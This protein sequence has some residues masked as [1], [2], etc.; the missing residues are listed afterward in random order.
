VNKIFHVAVREFVATVATKGFI[1]GIVITPIIILV[2]IF[3]MRTLFNEEAPRIEGE[4]TVIDPTGEVFDGIH[5]YLQPETIAER[6]G[7]LKE[8]AE[9]QVPAELKQLADSSGKADAA[10][11]ALDAVLG[12]V[13]QL[14]VVRLDVRVDPEKAKEPLRAGDASGGGRLALIMIHDDAVVKQEDRERFGSYDLFVKEKL[15]DRIEDE[16]KSGVRAAIIDSRV[17]LANLDLEEIQALTSVAR[18][19]SRTVTDEGEKET[20]EILNALMPM[21]FMMLLFVSVLSGGQY[22]MTTTIEDKSSRVIEVLLSAVSPMQLMT[23]KIIG[24][25]FVG[26]LI[27]GAYAGMGFGALVAFALVGMLDLSLF[28]YLIIFYFIAFFV[29]ASLM[30]A[31]GA[32]VNEMREAQTFMTPVMLTMII[33]WVLWMPITR[34]PNSM[35][36]VVTSFLPPINTFVMLLRMTSTAPPPLWQVWLSILIGLASVYAAV[37]FA[38]KVFRIGILMYGKP[39]DFKTLV[40]WVRMA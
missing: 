39:P 40:R 5:D 12:E 25:M 22:L 9:Q 37:W 11:M 26:F 38:A 18:V 8:L 4:V 33:P 32:A 7:D 31:I 13:P 23:G 2:A 16:I 19:R 34:D 30:A 15:D 24:Q 14:D 10:R 29:I 27:L 21:A 20:N 3:G 35:F 6:R 1:L 28:I 17:R 36:A